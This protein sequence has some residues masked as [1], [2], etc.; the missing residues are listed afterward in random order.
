[1]FAVLNHRAMTSADVPSEL[2][3]G[4]ALLLWSLTGIA[5]LAT[6][7]SAYFYFLLFG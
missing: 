4:P 6:A 2:R 5:L 3:P 1:V 7:S